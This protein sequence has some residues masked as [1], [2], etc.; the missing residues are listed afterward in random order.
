MLECLLHLS[1]VR[2]VDVFGINLFLSGYFLG[3]FFLIDFQSSLQK[4]IFI[5]LVKLVLLFSLQIKLHSIWNKAFEPLL[6][7]Q[8]HL[9]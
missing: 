5:G 4:N 1:L 9:L 8:F 7:H 2:A 3:L 6:F